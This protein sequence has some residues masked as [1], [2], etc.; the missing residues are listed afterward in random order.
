MRPVA[1][2]RRNCFENVSDG[3]LD[4][5]V[6][7]VLYLSLPGSPREDSYG[8]PVDVLKNR[9]LSL[10]KHPLGP[11]GEGVEIW[12]IPLQPNFQQKG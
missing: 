1:L 6:T 9:P 11:N 12:P 2:G 7:P 8:A 10:D 4:V 3:P 5:P